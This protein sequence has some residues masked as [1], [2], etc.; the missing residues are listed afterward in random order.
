MG[1]FEQFFAWL[2]GQL[3]VAELPMIAADPAKIAQA[4]ELLVREKRVVGL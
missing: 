2:N 3:G 1:F 4:Y